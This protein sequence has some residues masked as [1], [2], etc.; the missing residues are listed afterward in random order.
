LVVFSQETWWDVWGPVVEILWS[1][2][3]WVMTPIHPILVGIALACLAHYLRKYVWPIVLYLH[4]YSTKAK[5]NML[6]RS[7]SSS[8][9]G[10]MSS[11]L[12]SI[13]PLTPSSS[14]SNVQAITSSSSS[15]SSTSF[16]NAHTSSASSS[17]SSSSHIPE[18]FTYNPYSIRR[19]N[20]R[21]DEDDF[22]VRYRARESPR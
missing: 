8:R 6:F 17:P 21:D 4:Q 20:S 14:F 13:A 7:G 3:W 18:L 2:Y 1:I 9:I 16:S 22:D 5:K 10:Q 19:S 15:L 11:F 12:S